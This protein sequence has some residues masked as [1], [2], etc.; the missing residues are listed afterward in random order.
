MAGELGDNHNGYIELQCEDLESSGDV[1]KL[2]MAGLSTATR[3][4]HL[5]PVDDHGSEAG[6]NPVPL[7]L[8]ADLFEREDGSSM[9]V[10]RGVSQ[11]TM[12]LADFRPVRLDETP[13]A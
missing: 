11:T 10:Q 13:R 4:H 6:V 12:R 3:G 9:Q 2:L 1:G 8:G 7:G 5:E